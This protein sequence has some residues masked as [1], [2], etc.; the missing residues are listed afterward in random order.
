MR[1]VIPAAV[2]VTAADSDH[3]KNK[4]IIIPITIAAVLL[5]LIGGCALYLGDYY[6]A[7]DYALSALESTDTVTVSCED[8][9]TAFIPENAETG[10]IFYQGA[11]V[12]SSAYAPLM[13]MLADKGIL[14]ILEDMPANLAILGKN[15]AKGIDEL[16]PQISR[17]YIGGHSMG[18]FVAAEF[19][20]DN[21]DM[22]DG[23]VLLA[24][25]AVT[26]ISESSME[27]IALYGSE[28]GVL[29]MDSVEK[30]HVNLPDDVF[31]YTIEGGCHAGFGSYG[32]QD[33]D[34]NPTISSAEQLSIAAE[35]I[36][37]H[38]TD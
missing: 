13:M 5:L 25:F 22:I 24:S 4:K 1:R 2:T 16:Y 3:M 38:I 20:A 11:K 21:T 19:A 27:V 37:E 18:G 35:I 10:F 33:G 8:G 30:N 36:S 7:D 31:E 34:G 12:E 23:V 14:C 15:K 6:H 28:D 32:A 17:W 29:N 9:Y 26:D